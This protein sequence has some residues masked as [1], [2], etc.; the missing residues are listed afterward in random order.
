MFEGG[1]AASR[2][3]PDVYRRLS[4]E[5]D[6]AFFDAG[7]VSQTAAFDGVHLD[8][9]NTRAIGTALVPIVRELLNG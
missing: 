8:A 2:Q 5:M 4:D 6:C 3:L 1:D 7:R 9:A